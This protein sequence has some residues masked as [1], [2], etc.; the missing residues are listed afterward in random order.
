M[1][2]FK[3]ESCDLRNCSDSEAS[4]TWFFS[5]SFSY[6]ALNALQ[7]NNE[8]C[9]VGEMR[10]SSRGARDHPGEPGAGLL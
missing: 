9:I 4:C 10:S 3:E 2:V 6:V 7:A 5:A 8:V 1:E